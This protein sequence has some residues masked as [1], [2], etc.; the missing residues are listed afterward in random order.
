MVKMLFTINEHV[1]PKKNVISVITSR[2][3]DI[4]VLANTTVP[5]KW[6]PDSRAAITKETSTAAADIEAKI[7]TR[8]A[9][10]SRTID[11]G[12]RVITT[13][14]LN[15]FSMVRAVCTFISTM[16]GKDSRIIS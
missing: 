15:R 8:P 13:C 10:A 16:K 12:P 7:E 9:L 11:L 6:R 4:A 5:T 2:G 1:H 14:R 3:D